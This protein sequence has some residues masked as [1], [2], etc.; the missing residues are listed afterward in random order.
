MPGEYDD[1]DVKAISAEIGDSLFTQDDEEPSDAPITPPVEKAPPVE[2]AP[3]E[4]PTA[5]VTPAIVPGQ[6]S[7]AK[8]LPKSWKKDMAPH[9]EK[10][11]PEVHDYVYARENDVMRGIQQYQQGYQSWDTLTKPFS[12]IFQ[13]NPDVNPI[14]LMQGLMNTHLQLLNPSAPIEKKREMA[15]RILSDYGITLDGAQIT[16]ADPGLLAELNTLRSELGQIKQT[17]STQQ[18]QAHD[19]QVQSHLDA[20]NTFASKPENEYFSEVGNDILRFIQTGVAK[21]LPSAYEMACW[22]NP[23]IRAKMLAKQQAAAVPAQRDAK[24]KFVNVDSLETPPPRSRVKGNIDSTIDGIV[25][26]HYQKH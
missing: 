4:T 26:S 17:F 14:Q 21:D 23:G 12:P 20:I 7:V 16:Q 3:V 6:N 24:G 9:W 15:L 1:M 19:A 22:A 10:L 8:A 13:Q 25:A 2:A 5:P 11:P 18:K